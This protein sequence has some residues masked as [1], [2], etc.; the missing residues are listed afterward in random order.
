M[1]TSTSQD[2]LYYTH[3]LQSWHDYSSGL[4]TYD[5]SISNLIASN[6]YIFSVGSNTHKAELIEEQLFGDINIDGSVDILDVVSLVSFILETDFPTDTEFIAADQN[7]D[8][9][10]NVMDI[11]LLVDQILSAS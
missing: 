9:T 10:L 4:V 1:G 7:N 2:G 3:D 6:E 5:L 11:V 8:D